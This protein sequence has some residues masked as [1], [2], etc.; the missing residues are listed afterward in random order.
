MSDFLPKGYEDSKSLNEQGGGYMKFVKG[1][2]RFR[3]MCAPIVGWEWWEETSEGKKTPKRVK[4]DTKID[5]TTVSD[6][7]SIKR[8]WAM[9]VYNY[10]AKKLQI[11][12]ITQKGIQKTLTSYAGD[13]DWGSPVGTYDIV[14]TRTGDGLE[15]EY[16]VMPKPKSDMDEGIVQLYKDTDISL[17][18]LYEGGDPFKV[19]KEKEGEDIAEEA[20][21]SIP[22]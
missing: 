3:I 17:G 15:T 21:K 8:F 10:E 6:P 13:S 16:G 1:V 22:F 7:E 2:N 11:L 5:V 18:A 12:E 14:I 9:V 20:D 19:E 4:I